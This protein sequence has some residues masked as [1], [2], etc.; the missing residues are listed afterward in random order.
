MSN[1]IRLP[2]IAGVEINTDQ[3][4]RFNLNALHKASGGK[5]AKRPKSWLA[6]KQ[7]QELI[8]ELRQDSA[9][10]ENVIIVQKGGVSPGTF[11][12]ELLAIS[13]AG[14][15]SPSFQLKVNQVF[16]DHKAGSL[17]PLIPQSLPD[18]LRLA[19]ELAEESEAR[20]KK[21]LELQP[22]SDVYDRLIKAE[23]TLCP[24]D[25]AKT[26]QIRPKDLFAWLSSNKWIYKRVGCSH[27]CAY[28][29]KIQ[30]GYMYHKT[31]TVYREDG[32]EKI[33]EQAR[34]TAKGL[35]KIAKSLEVEGAA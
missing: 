2:V 9:L 3:E 30:A 6:T 1:V 25:A 23:G 11:A 31:K 24:T 15:I 10:G 8:E 29:D 27:W 19:A 4:G 17:K 16:I 5:D 34:V 22:K 26:L 18:A 21:I 13:Y 35:T 28:Q 14:W 12:H 33:T 32:S 7:A 20:G